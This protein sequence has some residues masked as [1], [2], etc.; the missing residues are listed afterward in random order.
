ML[1]ISSFIHTFICLV[2]H[3]C[4]QKYVQMF[5]LCWYPE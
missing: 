4:Y 5:T 1:Y 3:W 2:S